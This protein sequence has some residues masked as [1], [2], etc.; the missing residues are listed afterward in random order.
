VPERFGPAFISWLK[1]ALEDIVTASHSTNQSE[2]PSVAATRDRLVEALI[3][4]ART[5]VGDIAGLE[6]VF[7][8]IE[9]TPPPR[10][11]GDIVTV[12][13][14][15]LPAAARLMLTF[16]AATAEALARR[17]LFGATQNIDEELI[18]DCAAET[19]NVLAGQA[20]AL[21]SDASL[22]M[23]FSLPR[24]IAETQFELLTRPDLVLAFASELGPFRVELAFPAGRP[25]SC[26]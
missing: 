13:D 11:P 3:E 24:N 23:T 17:M 5:A 21:L 7:N 8:A 26:G 1:S 4:A 6:V 25:S 20:K 9:R 15:H 10:T 22:S 18:K 14:L 2:E 12:V 19:A 16:P